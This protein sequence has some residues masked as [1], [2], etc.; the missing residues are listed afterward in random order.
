MK[1]IGYLI[2]D[3]FE[4][5]G[6]DIGVSLIVL[7]L[8]VFKIFFSEIQCI[9][10]VLIVLLTF[11]LYGLFLYKKLEKQKRISRLENQLVTLG[12]EKEF[13]VA[14][15]ARKNEELLESVKKWEAAFDDFFRNSLIFLYNSLG[16]EERDR[17]SVYK[18]ENNRFVLVGRYSKNQTLNRKGRDFYPDDEGFIANGWRQG[19][20]CT[21]I[22][23]NPDTNY[24]DYLS[25]VSNLC[26][27]R[28][29]TLD[30]ISMKSRSYCINDIARAGTNEKIGIIVLESVVRL[31]VLAPVRTKG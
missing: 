7:W 17:I 27:I 1:K 18:H 19:E 29:G 25:E 21:T 15:F 5:Y 14:V 23:A 26:K 30:G 9:Y 31:K 8:G 22:G 16:Y 2:V 24:D 20:F 6:W 11:A 10:K 12:D 4:D 13:G 3:F 28:K